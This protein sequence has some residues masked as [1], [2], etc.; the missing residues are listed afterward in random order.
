[1]A[2]TRRKLTA[3]MFTD[4]VGYSAMVHA[5]EARAHQLLAMHRALLRRCVARYGGAQIE[6][7]G[8]GTL[9]IFDSGLAAVECAIAVQDALRQRNAESSGTQVRLRIGL[10]Q[11]DVERG[12]GTVF[13]D[14]VNVCARL[15]P[16]SPHGGIAASAAVVGQVHGPLRRHFRDAGAQSL[17]NI[18]E[19]VGMFVLDESALA[20]AAQD[21]EPR[22]APLL[23]RRAGWSLAGAA[24]LALV[25]GAALFLR[26]H[27]GAPLLD[28]SLAILPLENLSTEPGSAEF[29][30]GLH[31]SLLTEVS[32]T[33]AL[34]VISR[35]S[36]MRYAHDRPDAGEIGRQLKVG[37]VLEGS[38]QTSGARI[39]VNVQLIRTA[40]DEHVWAQVYD[41]DRSDLFALQTDISREI[42]RKI[43][44]NLALG[45]LPVSQRPTQSVEA[46]DLYLRA[47][48]HE[49]GDVTLGFAAP[50][51]PLRLLEQAVAFDDDFALAHAALARFNL[52]GARWASYV[53]P[54]K[55]D[56]Y[57]ARAMS[58]ARR[59][60][61]LAPKSPE[62]LLAMGMARYWSDRNGDVARG[63]F[64][65]ALQQRPGFPLA[66]YLL[67]GIYDRS[68]NLDK[69]IELART[70]LDI[71]P[72]NDKAHEQLTT[73]LV[74]Q[75]RYAEA[76]AA[77]ANWLE[78]TQTRGYVEYLRAQ[79]RFYRTGDIGA[80]KLIAERPPDPASGLTQDVLDVDRW[81]LATYEGRYA[82]AASVNRA[83]A[84]SFVAGASS[85]YR[86]AHQAG[87]ALELQG[88][89]EQAAHYLRPVVANLRQAVAQNPQ[90][91]YSQSLLGFAQA[92]LGEHDAALVNVRHAM[93]ASAP[94]SGR[95][96]PAGHYQ[97]TLIFALV[98]AHLGLNDEAI[99][100]LDW[101]LSQPSSVHLY[102]VAR[103][104][105]WAPLAD[106]PRFRALL[107]K[108]AVTR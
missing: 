57:V 67:S 39:R 17:K 79:L 102:M 101:L 42:A 21:L 5:D 59:A 2:R 83:A 55:V 106:D 44:G 95:G 69:S 68:G 23:S 32:K 41:R 58:A 72:V 35:T 54:A 91:F 77:Y 10:H 64:E 80:W 94:A 90:D 52:W 78:I 70:L 14:G 88:Q 65:Q 34:R 13:G 8:D 48:A 73:Q 53:D 63:Y 71:D 24:A 4:V 50:D 18:A 87:Q 22:R 89:H 86:W 38:V 40:T 27:L 49:D 16:L 96:A 105:Q 85:D 84:D 100:R 76:D 11:G 45:A 15:E 9:I 20:A 74:R 31:D 62:S 30:A 1:M 92:L 81:I 25:V 29:V 19:P 82:D 7:A 6:E 43:A 56:G 36:V 98:A 108:Y 75:R 33:P 103:D 47:I 37:H 93:E 60:I 3:V 26:A 66:L 12:Q 61:A 51:E 99:A 107:Q 104:P 28:A 97:C 46:Y